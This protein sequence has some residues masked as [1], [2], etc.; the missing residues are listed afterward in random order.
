[1]RHSLD[2]RL[3]IAAPA[4]PPGRGGIGVVRISGPKTTHI[5]KGILGT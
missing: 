4:T 3:T 5:A 1:M 2:N